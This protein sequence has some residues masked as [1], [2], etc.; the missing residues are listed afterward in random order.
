MDPYRGADRRQ[1][2]FP[3]ESRHQWPSSCRTQLQVPSQPFIVI[4]KEMGRVTAAPYVEEDG[5]VSL[6]PQSQKLA[7]RR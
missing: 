4:R 1:Q 3:S 7:V 5:I 2:H 6:L